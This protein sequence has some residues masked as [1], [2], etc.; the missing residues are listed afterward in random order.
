VVLED[1]GHV[2]QFEMAEETA[3]IIRT[4]LSELPPV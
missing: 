3:K 1:C 4:F 2:P